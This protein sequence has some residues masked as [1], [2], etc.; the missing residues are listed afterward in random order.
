MT[1]ADKLYPI[2]DCRKPLPENIE[3]TFRQLRAL[4]ENKKLT[5]FQIRKMMI[6]MLDDLDTEIRALDNPDE[7]I[8]DAINDL[9]N[10]CG[11]IRHETVRNTLEYL[12]METRENIWNMKA[13][14]LK[15]EI[16]SDLIDYNQ[17]QYEVPS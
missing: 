6:G 15:A 13:F 12:E 1:A 4:A 14:N 10:D 2:L 5:A 7:L 8:E 9:A 11:I 3:W 16:L 17:N